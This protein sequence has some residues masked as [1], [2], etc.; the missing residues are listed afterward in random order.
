LWSS[1]GAQGGFSLLKRPGFLSISFTRELMLADQLHH[2]WSV[3]LMVMHWTS[4]ELCSGK[5]QK[6]SVC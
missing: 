3:Y 4:I 1:N 2:L 5:V 6:S